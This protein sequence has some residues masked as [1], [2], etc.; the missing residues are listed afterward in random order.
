MQRDLTAKGLFITE[1]ERVKDFYIEKIASE[2]AFC[3]SEWTV[4][5]P[6]CRDI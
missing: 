2:G 4:K 1:N 5:R 6:L 3:K